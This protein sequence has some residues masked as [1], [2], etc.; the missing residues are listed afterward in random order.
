M[1]SSNAQDFTDNAMLELFRAEVETHTQT[2]NEGLLALEKDPGQLDRIEELMRAAHSIKGAARIVGVGDGVKVA[3]A[4]EDCL[5]AAQNGQVQLTSEATDILLRG[6][7]ALTRIAHGDESAPDANAL[8]QLLQDIASIRSGKPRATN[9]PAVAPEPLAPGLPRSQT[10]FGNER[11]IVPVTPQPPSIDVGTDGTAR[12]I[13]VP[14]NLDADT[15]E[16]LRRVLVELLDA[17]A[18]AYRLDLAAVREVDLSGLALLTAFART[19]RERAAGT[20]L[21]LVN[22]GPG[23]AT[24]F[25]LTG[26]ADVYRLAGAGG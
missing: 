5:V 6:V 3:H 1:A 15:A 4:M 18:G 13:T 19:A 11:T 7:D 22:V 8:G 24:L 12:V 25:R 14:G 26:L 2:L 16:R 9:K 10:E 20:M 21:E 23:P 17:G